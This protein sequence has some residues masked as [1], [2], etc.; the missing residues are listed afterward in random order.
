MPESKKFEV[1]RESLESVQEFISCWAEENGIPVKLAMKI[2]ICSD[3]IVSNVVFYSGATYF[4]IICDKQNA[5][6]SISFV[7]DGKAFDPLTET[8]DPD[9]TA[10][11]EEREIGGLGIFM[12]KK[13]M[14]EVCYNR[15]DNK[16]IL[17]LKTK[18]I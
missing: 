7:D 9:I 12:V 15:V 13:M 1:S 5:I 18:V 10:S 6:V 3:E 17:T 11:V 2:N 8:K 4:E 16:N 14:N